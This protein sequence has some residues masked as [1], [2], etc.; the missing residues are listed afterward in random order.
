[1]LRSITFESGYITVDHGSGPPVQHKISDVLRAADI[2]VLTITSLELLTK[3][4]Q[5]VSILVQTLIE[6][7]TISEDLAEGYDLQYIANTLVSDLNAEF[8]GN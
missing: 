8:G 3:L 1:M 6:D 4:A 5:V 7:G 2:P